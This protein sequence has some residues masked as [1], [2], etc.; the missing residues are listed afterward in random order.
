MHLLRDLRSSQPCARTSLCHA[1]RTR[2]A[3]SVGG[4]YWWASCKDRRTR[5]GHFRVTWVSGAPALAKYERC[6]SSLRMTNT[7]ASPLALVSAPT[8]PAAGEIG[9]VLIDGLGWIHSRVVCA[10]AVFSS[11]FPRETCVMLYVFNGVVGDPFRR[12]EF[13]VADLLCPPLLCCNIWRHG[14]WLRLGVRAFQPGERLPVHC[15]RDLLPREERYWNEYGLPVSGSVAQAGLGALT[16][17]IGVAAAIDTARSEGR[18]RFDIQPG[19]AI[20]PP[21]PFKR[22]KPRKAK[23]ATVSL[24]L[25]IV[26]LPA[27]FDLA[28]F[29]DSVEA[30]LKRAKLGK[31]DGHGQSAETQELDIT[32]IGRDAAAMLAGLREATCDAVLPRS[33]YCWVSSVWDSEPAER[34]RLRE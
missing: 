25:P 29:E 7:P 6:S 9:A 1:T 10:D 2:R 15:F 14:L 27:D 8:A 4:V 3:R 26:E 33:A 13:P 28:E 21:P 24:V 22:P 31:L 11:M 18:L 34:V 32:F 12:T 5:Q 30:F 19:E 17:E 23:V 16:D 20:L